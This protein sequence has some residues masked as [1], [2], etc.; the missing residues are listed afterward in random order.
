MGIMP[1]STQ[2]M[3]TKKPLKKLPPFRK[4]KKWV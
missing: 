4:K 3:R 1:K 2:R